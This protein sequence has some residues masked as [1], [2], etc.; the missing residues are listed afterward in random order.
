MKKLISLLLALVLMFAIVGCST[1][2]KE[3]RESSKE[4]VESTVEKD[5]ESGKDD[6]KEVAEVNSEDQSLEFVG[7]SETF[8]DGGFPGE[9]V[10]TISSESDTVY[11]I[12]TGVGIPEGTEIVTTWKSPDGKEIVDAYTPEGGV[13]NNVLEFH[14]TTPN[15]LVVGTYHIMVEVTL[16]GKDV[17]ISEQFSVKGV[18]ESDSSRE[19]K[20]EVKTDNVG[21]VMFGPVNYT[22]DYEYDG[23]KW[24]A[25]YTAAVVGVESMSI[26]KLIEWGYQDPELSE[27]QEL[28]L[29][30]LKYTIDN[31]SY[32]SNK[33]E[34]DYFTID[35]KIN[36][37]GVIS[38]DTKMIGGTVDSGFEGCLEDAYDAALE[39]FVAEGDYS[40][41]IKSGE[42][43]PK[44]IEVIGNIVAIVDKSRE[45]FLWLREQ[46]AGND[47]NI[48]TLPLQ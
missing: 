42:D 13:E 19:P 8:D 14:I 26:E 46:S 17:M 7:F 30:T 35:F 6:N 10:D 9:I 29:I 47:T 23:S 3:D 31:P 45:N 5:E 16:E 21:S 12:L 32:T 20:K 18:E 44:H 36:F 40:Y 34:P 27:Y 2:D 15:G 11:L 41:K 33:T 28:K 24:Y 25:D 37:T 1:K 48:I 22:Y 43:L 38:G 4:T 39:S